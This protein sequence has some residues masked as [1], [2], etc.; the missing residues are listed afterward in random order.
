MVRHGW[1]SMT[2][3]CKICLLHPFL[4]GWVEKLIGMG[5]S[6][7]EVAETL[8]KHGL[9]IS[10]QAVRRHKF[11]MDLKSRVERLEREV[12]RYERGKPLEEL[13]LKKQNQRAQ[14]KNW[15]KT[16]ENPPREALD[17]ISRL[18]DEI[19]LME[20]VIKLKKLSKQR[21]LR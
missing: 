14:L 15:I 21:L 18:D 20:K 1:K 10:Y 17:A 11:H 9:N 7:R 12:E 8:R 4:L 16:E 2:R 5:L 19:K 6:L 13:L 3:V